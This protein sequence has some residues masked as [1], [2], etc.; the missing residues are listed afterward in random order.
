M[1][2]SAVFVPLAFLSVAVAAV[3]ASSGTS[4][5][6]AAP[7]CP[8]LTP[9]QI[10]RALGFR[11]VS[12]QTHTANMPNLWSLYCDYALGRNAEMSL[13]VYRGTRAYA[14]EKAQ[15]DESIG[16]ANANANG[17]SPGTCSRAWGQCEGG[18]YFGHESPLAGLGEKALAFPGNKNGDALV[19]FIWKRDTFLV[20]SSGPYGQAGPDQAQLITFARLLLRSHFRLAR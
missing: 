20:E 17:A 8:K 5:A 6:L 3:L 18:T 10:A 7:V 16:T 11:V 12:V 19:M 4:Q 2:R 14:A 13:E 9:A 15:I 1:L